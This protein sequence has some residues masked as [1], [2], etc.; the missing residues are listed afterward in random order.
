MILVAEIK[1]FGDRNMKKHVWVIFL[2]IFLCGYFMIRQKPHQHQPVTV[3][4]NDQ[5]V[6][7][8]EFNVAE[9]TCSEDGKGWLTGDGWSFSRKIT[10]VAPELKIAVWGEDF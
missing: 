4:Q 8:H 5:T 2:C 1:V 9:M 10:E 7:L 3:M 6:D